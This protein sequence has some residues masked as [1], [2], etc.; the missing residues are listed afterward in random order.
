VANIVLIVPVVLQSLM[1]SSFIL[2]SDNGVKLII[3]LLL[4]YIVTTVAGQ[5][6]V[7]GTSQNMLIVKYLNILAILY[8]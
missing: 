2:V 5:F 6:D 1:L 7:Y 4:C 3:L 8:T